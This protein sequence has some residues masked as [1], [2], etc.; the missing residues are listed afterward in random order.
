M[1]KNWPEI[2][3][4]ENRR[5]RIAIATLDVTSE[6]EASIAAALPWLFTEQEVSGPVPLSVLM[7]HA[8]RKNDEFGLKRTYESV[9]RELN[10][11][12]ALEEYHI[13]TIVLV[14]GETTEP[15]NMIDDFPVPDDFP[16][17]AEFGDIVEIDGYKWFIAE[18]SET[19]WFVVLAP[20]ERIFIDVYEYKHEMNIYIEELDLSDRAYAVLKKANIRT[21]RDL[22]GYSAVDIGS[23]RNCGPKTLE[24]IEQRLSELGYK[25]RDERA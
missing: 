19:K 21:V 23:I 22:L 15:P 20:L 14:G 4:I 2:C 3:K 8:G 7:D 13:P 18:I 5:L 12:G 25:L 10:D 1:Y 6:Q 11:W 16:E 24:E 17:D 9:S